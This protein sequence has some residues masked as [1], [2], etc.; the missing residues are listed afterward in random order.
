MF[1][2]RKLSGV[3]KSFEYLVYTVQYS[4]KYLVYS[5][6]T[7][8]SAHYLLYRTVLSTWCIV[9]YPVPG[10]DELMVGM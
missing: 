9:Q 8:Y 10:G 1:S 7:V 6:L 2:S 4:A 3:Q 5:T